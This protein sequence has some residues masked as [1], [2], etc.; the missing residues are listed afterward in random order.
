MN[1]K[2]MAGWKPVRDS[3]YTEDKRYLGMPSL[4]LG[5]PQL[6]TAL[7]AEASLKM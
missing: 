3:E 6:G 2:A 5:K 4:Q 7:S 1:W